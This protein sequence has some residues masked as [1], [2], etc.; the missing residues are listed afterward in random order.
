MQRCARYGTM[1]HMWH[2][3]LL[4]LIEVAARAAGVTPATMSRRCS[5]SGDL[6]ARLRSGRDITS[7]RAERIVQWLSDHWSD[8]VEWPSGLPRP[9]AT[10]SL[11]QSTVPASPLD[12]PPIDPV[13]AAR[14]AHARY[15]DALG[16]PSATEAAAD[17]LRI[18]GRLDLATGRV[19]SPNALCAAL[20]VNRSVYDDVVRRYA[21]G[22]R[23]RSP[24]RGSAAARMLAALRSAGDVRFAPS[25]QEA[26]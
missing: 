23:R 17:A 18:G 12:P 15:V 1:R 26:A 19:A 20:G 7:R 11:P 24:R 21:N 8:A 25:T 16:T 13:A 10:R 5:G 2:R 3:A 4:N 14:A 6:Y 22:R 9:S